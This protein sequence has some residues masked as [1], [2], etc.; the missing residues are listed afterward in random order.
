MENSTRSKTEKRRKSKR[1]SDSAAGDERPGDDGV[2]RVECPPNWPWPPKYS[3]KGAKKRKVGSDGARP[4]PPPVKGK[5]VE[6]AGM[7]QV[8]RDT[9]RRA[10]ITGESYADH[11]LSQPEPASHEGENRL[12]ALTQ[13]SDQYGEGIDLDGT[14]VSYPN[15]D[16]ESAASAWTG[17]HAS[18]KA[19]FMSVDEIKAAAGAH[20]RLGM[21]DRQGDTIK[22]LKRDLKIIHPSISRSRLEALAAAWLKPEL[23]QY[24]V[25]SDIIGAPLWVYDEVTGKKV[26]ITPKTQGIRPHLCVAVHGDGGDTSHNLL[27]HKISSMNDYFKPVSA[28]PVE[29]EFYKDPLR[30]TEQNPF[31]S[32]LTRRQYKFFV[33]CKN[34][35]T[36][37]TYT[38][39]MPVGGY[40]GNNQFTDKEFLFSYGR[41]VRVLGAPT[42]PG[43]KVF[44]NKKT[45]SMTREEVYDLLATEGCFLGRTRYTMKQRGDRSEFRK[46]GRKGVSRDKKMKRVTKAFMEA[47]SSVVGPPK[48][49]FNPSS[50]HLRDVFDDKRKE[51]ELKVDS[52]E[53]AGG[54]KVPFF[55]TGHQ[56]VADGTNSAFSWGYVEHIHGDPATNAWFNSLT[57]GEQ[58]QVLRTNGYPSVTPPGQFSDIFKPDPI[59]PHLPLAEYMKDMAFCHR[60][61]LASILFHYFHDDTRYHWYGRLGA[62]YPEFDLYM[63]HPDDCG[64]VHPFMWHWAMG[65]M[66][67]SRFPI[68]IYAAWKFRLPLDDPQLEKATITKYFEN[69]DYC[70]PE[71]VKLPGATE[72]EDAS[73]E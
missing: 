7:S 27:I 49:E 65:D 60:M 14:F 44:D 67:G 19:P 23:T 68:R 63:L 32:H 61:A 33:V 62:P 54:G 72:V 21:E 28:E 25:I 11:G 18:A 8:H 37:E 38:A 56:S 35:D 43:A 41:A 17:I 40:I 24:H 59:S 36:D 3:G 20:D 12:T 9:Q 46:A 31:V 45:R 26:I 6:I 39:E 4:K 1:K 48:E 73:P 2:E 64:L 55:H 10:D 70:P 42:S 34:D 66:G 47:L 51:T 22:A 30:G 53:R 29:G 15:K 58:N 69:Y 16:L 57:L 71:E 50:T 13:D 5:E 52:M